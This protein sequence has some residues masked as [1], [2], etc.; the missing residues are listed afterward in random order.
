MADVIVQQL[1]MLISGMNAFYITVALLILSLIFFFFMIFR[2]EMWWRG[3]MMFI[4]GVFF[5]VAIIFGLAK[6]I[7]PQSMASI[8]WIGYGIILIGGT[9]TI[10][11]MFYSL[12][13]LV[14]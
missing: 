14:R 1:N 4:S 8:G 2:D 9:L 12:I 7:I 5:Q 6:E 3:F 13:D 10:L 11:G